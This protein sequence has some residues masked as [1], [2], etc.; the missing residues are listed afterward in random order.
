MIGYHASHEE[1]GPTDLLRYVQHAE[2]AGFSAAMCSDHFHP[3]G[4]QQGH[5]A[6][7]WSWLGAAMQATSLSFGTVNAPGQRYHPA[8]IAQAA[9]T[10][11]YMF[12]GRFWVAVGSGEALNESITGAAWPLKSQRNARLLE[13]V[14]VMRALW[15]GETVTHHGLVTVEEA[16]LYTRPERPPMIVGAAITPATAGW[17]GD[18]ADALITVAGS[19]KEMQQ[20]IDAFRSGGGADKPIFLQVHLASAPDEREAQQQAMA[21]WRFSALDTT[22][23]AELRR[24]AQFDAASSHV[25]IED[26]SGSVRMSPDP[27]RHLEWLQEDLAMGYERIYLH[28][29]GPD[30]ERF[31]DLFGERVLP[32]L[33]PPS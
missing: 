17:M 6:F 2:Q 26:L 29:V 24:P 8:V 3:W 25:R 23:L 31:I 5:S 14:R 18:W 27:E 4:E 7:A 21:R 13:C 11:A 22:V 1:N 33:S 16:K 30:Q 28:E 10:L 32:E 19:R 20:V 12:P 15:A 9:A